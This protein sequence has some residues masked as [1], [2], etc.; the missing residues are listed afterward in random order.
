MIPYYMFIERDTGARHYF[1]VPLERAL[2]VYSQA[3]QASS[4]LARTAR[5]P[6]MSCTPGP[7]RPGV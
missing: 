6:S 5:G 4:G 2:E 1:A 3:T 7:S